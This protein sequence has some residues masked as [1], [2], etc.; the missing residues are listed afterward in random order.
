MRSRN[1]HLL[2]AALT[3]GLA[4][5]AGAQGTRLAT[6]NLPAPVA[7]T[8]SDM[9]GSVAAVRHLS[10]GNVLVNDQARRRVL[11]LDK[12]MK[13]ISVVADSTSN[14]GNAYGA[15][16]GGLIPYRGDSTYFVD[17][18]SLSMMLIDANGKI[19]GIKAA[20]RPN[21]VMALSVPAMGTPGFDAK[22]R[23]IYR[24]MD[25]GFRGGARPE[26]G[27]PFVP[28]TPP[29]SAAL[30]RFDLAARKLDTVAFYKIPKANV[31]MSQDANGGMRVSVTMNPLPI[32]DD[33][34]VLSDGSVALV[35]GQDYHVD[36]IDGD[37][38]KKSGEKVPYEWQRMTDDDKQRFLD[39]AKTAIENLRKTQTAANGSAT[40]ARA[41]DVG[42][43]AGAAMGGAPMVMTMTREGPG[44][45]APPMRVDIGGAGPNAAGGPPPIQMVSISELPDYKPVFGNSSVRADM[46]GRVWVRTIPTKP[47]AGPVYEV[48]DNTGKLVDRVMVPAGSTIAGF[49]AGGIVYLGVR[50]ATGGLKLQRIT[51]GK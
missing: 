6:R 21:D 10:N 45:G 47:T 19:V 11:L 37:G 20:P 43:M 29:D 34:A 51:L 36:I 12:D 42:A 41:A 30:V 31:Q 48:L 23:L 25:F 3:L 8:E 18:A 27:K 9:L 5:T 13:L 24:S 44:G 22:G 32:V 40:G 1:P 7:S 16:Q 50:D 15:R 2:S 39:S 14:T 46:D 26:P 49:G 4:A 35:R 28:P 33:W 17:P 38:V